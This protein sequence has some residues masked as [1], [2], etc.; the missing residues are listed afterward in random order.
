MKNLN[1]IIYPLT[2][3]AALAFAPGALAQDDVVPADSLP[4]G[5]QLAFRTSDGGDILG[6]VSAVNVAEL[7]KKSFSDYSLSNMSAL[8]TGYDGELWNMGSALVLVDGVPRDANNILPQE[9]ESISF[10]KGAQ[11]VVLYGSTAAKGA[12]LITT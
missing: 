5:I 1:N 12:I 7:D 10:L 6:G 2:A 3:A 9:I 4:Q 11:A 8:T